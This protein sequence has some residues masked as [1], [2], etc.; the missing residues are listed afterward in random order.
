MFWTL[1]SWQ[2]LRWCYHKG[3]LLPEIQLGN[4][5]IISLGTKQTH[6]L[7]DVHYFGDLRLAWMEIFEV[8]SILNL[9]LSSKYFF[10][11]ALE[12]AIIYA[13]LPSVMGIQT[14][15]WINL[16]LTLKIDL[17]SY[18]ILFFILVLDDVLESR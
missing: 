10:F 6:I 12:K 3:H 15:L 8:L 13:T 5:C 2:E 11:F 17:N 1:C 18:R 7:N 9:S 14:I 16:L 4:D